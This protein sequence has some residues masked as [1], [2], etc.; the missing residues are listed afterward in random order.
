MSGAYYNE[1]DP[2]AAAWLRELIADGLIAPG[3]VDERSIEDVRPD[4][5]AGFVQCHF[6][7]GIGIW[8]LALRQAGWP[9]D[10]P[11]W[12][13]SCPCQ[14]FSVAGKGGG[15]DD[16]RHLWPAF[17]WLIE[18][19]NAPIVLG[20]QVASQDGLAWLNLVSADLEA[21]GYAFGAVDTCAAGFGAPHIRQRL[22]WMADAMPAGRPEGWAGAGHG[23]LAGSGVAG[24]LEN[25]QLPAQPR[26]RSLGGPRLCDEETA[27]LARGRL[28][29]GLESDRA[30]P[31]LLHGVADTDGGNAGTER[32]QRSGEQR[33][34]PQDGGA[35]GV[36]DAVHS[37]RRSLPERRR[38]ER[39]QSVAGRQEAPSGQFLARQDVRPGPLNGLWRDADWLCCT[40]GKWRPVAPGTFP[41]A[42]VG[43]VRNRV[44][45]LRGAGNAINLAQAQGFIEAV[46]DIRA[47]VELA[48]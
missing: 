17:H 28:A 14:P 33:Q 16:E 26:Q 46:M 13:G 6:F 41:L 45:I 44:G 34:Q 43:T 36:G 47:Q 25:A 32:Q 7:A 18:Q 3:E 48:A 15:F 40:D 9:D 31:R 35:G 29:D 8:S 20:E 37:E 11:I 22:Y 38:D 27:R 1:H 12:T 21:T 24:G 10:E 19:S 30:D 23:S 39:N 42:P 5:L 4:E 2:F